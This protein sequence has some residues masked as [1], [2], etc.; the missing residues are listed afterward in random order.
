M[1]S[2]SDNKKIMIKRFKP[3]LNKCQIGLEKL[4]KGNEFV[5][6][7]VHLLSYKFP[8]INLNCGGSYIDSPDWIKSK[9]ATINPISKKIKK[10]TNAFNTL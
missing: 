4:M 8:K 7:Y 2:K 6:D 9:K 1:H 10:I 3:L 5:F